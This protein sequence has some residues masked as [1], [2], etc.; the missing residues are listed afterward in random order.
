MPGRKPECEGPHR[1]IG[2]QVPEQLAGRVK[3]V[4]HLSAS[5]TPKRRAPERQV[6]SSQL[7]MATQLRRLEHWRSPGP[8]RPARPTIWPARVRQSS[9]RSA[10]YLLT[11]PNWLPGILF[12]SS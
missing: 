1:R 8:S 9:L 3:S 11:S 2:R 5:E 10:Y 12:R 7:A 4:G 6:Q